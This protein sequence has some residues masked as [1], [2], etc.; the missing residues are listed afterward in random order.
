[1]SINA[2]VEELNSSGINDNFLSVGNFLAQKKWR[3]LCEG[4]NP[5]ENDMARYGLACMLENTERFMSSLDE[6]TRAVSIGDF[7]K[8][9]FPLVRAIFPELVANEIVSV[10][11][12]LGPVSLVFYMDFVYGSDKGSVRR[13]DTAFS[14]VAR[15]PNN[16]TYSSP[17]IDEEVVSQS[18]DNNIATQVLSYSPVVPGS[19]VIT[20][21]V[22]V[23]TDDGNGN[24]V[25]DIG[26]TPPTIDYANATFGSGTTLF[27]AA[28]AAQV[29][30]SYTYDMEANPQIPQMDL[31]L[32]SSPVSARPRKLRTNW[33]LESAF[34]LRSLHGM[35]AEVELTAAVGADI[36]FEIDREII[37]DLQRMA[38]AGSAYWNRTN[39]GAVSF[40]EHKLSIIDTFT[41]A[42][43]LVW[44]TTGRGRATWIVCG[45]S[46]ASVL[47]TLP[48]FVATPGQ[49]SGLQKGVYK[50]GRLNTLWDVYKDPFYP[51]D[52]FVMGFKG[53]SFLEAGYVYA[54][55]IPLYTTPTVVLDDFIARKGL[56]TQYGKKAINPLFY[57]TGEVG[58]EADLQAK[59]G[60]TVVPNGS[61]HGTAGR[62]VF[63]I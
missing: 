35:E 30:T 37:L 23:V 57:V 1:M 21:G 20:D 19:V 18:G 34:N 62:G 6:T 24:L 51:D 33:S 60:T 4:K 38:G 5:V 44:K 49:P 45:E 47:E 32:Q 39:N 3:A 42:S 40:T 54:P 12:M 13:G 28:P 10:Q 26:A 11:P 9:A 55:Y 2:L 43:N 50:A 29:T 59:A 61:S 36:R 58:T 17:Q 63:G 31:V 8:Y 41:R 53:Q 52:F 7:Q 14:S 22:Q 15:G 46:V 27:A 25:G 48:G 56:A 16:P